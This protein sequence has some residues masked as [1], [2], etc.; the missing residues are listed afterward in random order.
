[1]LSGVKKTLG[2]SLAALTVLAT[3]LAAAQG[4]T[5]ATQDLYGQWEGRVEPL[6]GQLPSGLSP[7]E[8]QALERGK[9][10]LNN[11]Q[12]F[13]R[14]GPGGACKIT[15]K[16]VNGP[17]HTEVG[18]WSVVGNVIKIDR[19]TPA[20][21]ASGPGGRGSLIGTFNPTTRRM[22]LDLPRGGGRVKGRVVLV[23]TGLP[24]APSPL[25]ATRRP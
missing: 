14:L 17:T 7:K 11:V 25:T 13:L 9:R 16:V 1:M 4:P 3:P 23:R 12:V 21:K 22:A 10:L 5:I 18:K 15:T 20:V 8:R 24:A 6:A 19:P 2:L